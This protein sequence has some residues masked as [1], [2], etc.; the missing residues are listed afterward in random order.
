[1]LRGTLAAGRKDTAGAHAAFLQAAEIVWRIVSRL[2]PLE[3][4][5][6]QRAHADLTVLMDGLKRS[7][8]EAGARPEVQTLLETV[9]SA[10]EPCGTAVVSGEA[11]KQAEPVH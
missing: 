6:F 3:A 7:A 4:A 1:V 9:L 10:T 5:G 2:S 11:R 8:A